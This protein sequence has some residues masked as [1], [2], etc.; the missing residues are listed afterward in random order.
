M[1]RYS[2]PKPEDLRTVTD[3]KGRV[4][5]MAYRLAERFVNSFADSHGVQG[6]WNNIEPHVQDLIRSGLAGVEVPGEVKAIMGIL[7][8]NREK[9]LASLA[10]GK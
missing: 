9:V 5:V 1:P 6:V 8:D 3:A 4:D 10:G 2:K 7:V